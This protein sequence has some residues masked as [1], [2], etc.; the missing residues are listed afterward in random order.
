MAKQ[1]QA[2]II[3]NSQVAIVSAKA[4]T[5]KLLTAAA[6]G[7]DRGLRIVAGYAQRTFLSGPRPSILDVRTG[8][9][10]NSIATEVQRTSER[11]VGRIG[12]NMPYGAYHE[13]GFQGVQQ[14]RAHT[15]IVDDL[16]WTSTAAPKGQRKKLYDRLGNLIGATGRRKQAEGTMV[17][18]VKAHQRT[19]NYRERPFLNPAL[20]ANFDEIQQEVENEMKAVGK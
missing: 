10:R 8:R 3:G 9:L 6:F 18:S 4:L 17:Q 5:P 11:V 2:R 19:V 13:F 12:T 20:E 14:V 15:R 16:N 7:L 1:M